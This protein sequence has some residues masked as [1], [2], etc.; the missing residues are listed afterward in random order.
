[1]AKNITDYKNWML[2]TLLD[3]YEQSTAFQTGVFS[4][5][6]MLS[7]SKETSLQEMLEQIDEKCLF[8]T[9]LDQLKAQKFIDYSWVK[10]EVGNLV[11]KVWLL[12]E[13]IDTCYRELGRVPAA[14]LLDSFQKLASAYLKKFKADSDFANY[15]RE[16]IQYTT[17]KKKLKAPFTENMTLNAD[18]LECLAKLDEAPNLMERVFSSRY[19]G[20]SKYFERILKSKVLSILREIQKETIGFD[21]DA[22]NDFL[23]DE[24]LL[25]ARGLY[26][27]P[28]IF[29]L[30]GSVIFQLDDGSSIDMSTQI[31]GAYINSDTVKHIVSVDGSQIQ[32]VVLIENKAN[33]V[34]YQAN[35]KESGDL[36]VYHGGFYSP[37]KGMLFTKIYEGC[38][39]ASFYH[40]SDIDLGGFR[41]FHR[42]R[43]NIIP[44]IQP[45]FMDADT[46]RANADTCLTIKSD[47]YLHQLSVLSENPE[48]S[49]FFD[50]I[51]YMLKN[52]VRLEQENLI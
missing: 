48:F 20:D 23:S 9:V 4:R 38:R 8:F 46:L 51:N 42:L 12:P 14:E 30:N 17:N 13:S 2:N 39:N 26:R 7:I 29:E 28:E 1:M 18:L 31:Y 11:D 27:W 16:A 43:K 32:R 10:Y 21:E 15:I 34:D 22:S 49:I 45:L 19:F 52:R 50:V 35:L 41:I 40:W 3:K 25:V 24:D 37:M 5:K 6:I 47:G 36:I 44:E 33:F